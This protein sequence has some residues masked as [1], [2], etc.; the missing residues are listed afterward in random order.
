MRWVWWSLALGVALASLGCGDDE[1]SGAGG[2]GASTST[3]T[4]AT[5][6]TST[7]TT[8]AGGGGGGGTSTSSGGG[9]SA[10][11]SSSSGGGGG[12]G[13][14]GGPA[15]YTGT[16][17]QSCAMPSDCCA[18]IPGCPGAAYP[19]N[20]VCTAEGACEQGPCATKADCVNFSG[21]ANAECYPLAGKLSCVVGCAVDGDCFGSAVCTAVA[22]DGSKYCAA[23][24]ALCAGDAECAGYGGCDPASGECRCDLVDPAHACGPS[25]VCVPVNP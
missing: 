21:V 23:P 19:A 22:D 15:L 12:A 5:T 1:P 13:A 16:C 24:P 2:A 17:R 18:G 20:V 14:G 10:T 6:S 9:A 8:S 3:S 11:T 4:D 25:L 7:S